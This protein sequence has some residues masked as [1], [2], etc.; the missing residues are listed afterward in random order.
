MNACTLHGVL[1]LALALVPTA[2]PTHTGTPGDSGGAFRIIKPAAEDCWYFTARR[3][4]Q[5]WQAHTLHSDLRAQG[6]RHALTRLYS[7]PTP[8]AI[9][10][11]CPCLCPTSSQW[12]ALTDCRTSTVPLP[13]A[14]CPTQG[15]PRDVALGV[16]CIEKG[17]EQ[18][19]AR[20][21]TCLCNTVERYKMCRGGFQPFA[22][23]QALSEL[24]A[25]IQ[26]GVGELE[27]CA[28][29]SC[30]RLQLERTACS[31]PRPS[32]EPF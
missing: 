15:L 14:P 10:S 20:V 32:S 9:L 31:N 1:S 16:A 21:I 17:R 19:S 27:T 28:P 30:C 25:T 18:E 7:L 8:S 6:Q 29:A 11:S 2:H 5:G 3:G 12:S 26:A 23:P 22:S 4:D 13:L 24:F